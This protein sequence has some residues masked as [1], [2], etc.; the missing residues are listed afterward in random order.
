MTLF[1]DTSACYA[2]LDADDAHHKTAAR[3]WRDCFRSEHLLVT[4]NYVLLETCALLQRWLGLDA[5]RAFHHDFLPLLTVEWVDEQRHRAG[6]GAVLTAARK[7]LSLVDCI[8]FQLMRERG[9]REVFS[10]DQHFAEQGF[11]LMP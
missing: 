7:R 4:S 1:V 10:F 5:V 3:L 9:L 2:A 8:S 11:I 6:V